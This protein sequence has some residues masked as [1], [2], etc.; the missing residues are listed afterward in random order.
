ML[1]NSLAVQRLRLGAFTEVPA[2][3]SRSCKS[4]GVAKVKEKTLVVMFGVDGPVSAL[5]AAGIHR[6]PALT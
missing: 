4:H 5:W 1:G 3:I 6:E 2:L